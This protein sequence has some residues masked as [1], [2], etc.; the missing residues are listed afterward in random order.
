MHTILYAMLTLAVW[1]WRKKHH[2]LSPFFSSDSGQFLVFMSSYDE[3][4]TFFFFSLVLSFFVS[5]H[6]QTL[7]QV[8][9]A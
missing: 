5:A 4:F 2:F 3:L 6:T 7:S 1:S 9:T 8:L